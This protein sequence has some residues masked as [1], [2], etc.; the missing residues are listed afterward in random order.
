MAWQVAAA[1]VVAGGLG[2]SRAKRK[3]ARAARREAEAQAREIRAQKA[4]VALAATQQ[5]EN[6]MLQFEELVN[7]NEAVN[8]YMGRT[9]RSVAALREREQRLYGKDVDRIRFQEQ[10]EK[11]RLEK[12]AQAVIRRGRA[13]SDAYKTQARLSLFET[14]YK[15]ASLA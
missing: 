2:S 14:A 1:F 15:A 7:Y 13:S 4:D 12:E 6:R 10:R 3:A 5:H 9:G 11:D 8:A